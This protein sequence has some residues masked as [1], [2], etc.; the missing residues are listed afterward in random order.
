M[1]VKRPGKGPKAKAAS[2]TRK[3]APTVAGRKRTTSDEFV[4]TEAVETDAVE[5]EAV[6]TEAVENEAVEN[7]A[8]ETE[9]VD[10]VKPTGKA[11]RPISRV[12]TI[13]AD[14]TRAATVAAPEKASATGGFASKFSTAKSSTSKWI[15]NRGGDSD[16]RSFTR[17]AA[18]TGMAAAIIGLIAL[19]LAFTPF[20]SIG[21]NKAFVDQV[22]T[23]QLT[24]QA[25]AKLC[26]PFAVSP[27]A[28]DKWVSAGR[29]ALT[30]DALVTFNKN[31]ET[32]RQIIVQSQ[33]GT[34]C[35]VDT[36]G[37]QNL[38]G[39]HGA[40]LGS[41]LLSRNVQ[42]SVL[43]SAAVRVQ[44]SMVKIDGTWLIDGFETL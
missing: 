40:V 16:G 8:V 27:S 24:S 17:T 42:G 30:G 13:K 28:V 37:V 1:A 6:E 10:D 12:S 43:D 35:K 19:I 41:L 22:S 23:T 14:P 32:Q 26:S 38:S 31:V 3:S 44:A 7:E 29:Q 2:S 11:R 21:D 18:V 39:D 25:E 20:A 5:N 36:L 4:E 33:T 9:A 34:D 15:A